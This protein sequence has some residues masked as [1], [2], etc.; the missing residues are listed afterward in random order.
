MVCVCVFVLAGSVLADTTKRAMT[1]DDILKEEFQ[2]FFALSPDGKA[3]AYMH[4]NDVRV[5]SVTG[6]DVGRVA[7]EAETGARYFL[8]K[9][10]PGG[11]RLAMQSE[12]SSG[13]G[14]AVWDRKK[15]IIRE[16]LNRE[17]YVG[18][19]S[20]PFFEWLD[21]ERILCAVFPRHF[22]AFDNEEVATRAWR[23]ARRRIGPTVSVLYS[24]ELGEKADGDHR[25]ELLVVDLSKGASTPLDVGKLE[26]FSV[27]PDGK[28]VAVLN[29][30][31]PTISSS[32]NPAISSFTMTRHW[33]V[34]QT[35]CVSRHS[36]NKGHC[37][38][39][40][41]ITRLVAVSLFGKAMR[42]RLVQSELFRI[43]SGTLRSCWHWLTNDDY[44]F[45]K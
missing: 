10:S 24:G 45:G 7:E 23:R 39:R 36:M 15:K 4:N 21:D 12:R 17:L 18:R 8:P 31:A 29:E 34:T 1:P 28:H 16:I 42:A 33:R 20:T 40:R 32:S 37:F 22:H 25:A 13:F 6:E 30:E 44:R 9:W 41:S 14:I 27:S 5:R 38:F 19:G 3:I 43:P 35:A 11:E 26:H 2:G